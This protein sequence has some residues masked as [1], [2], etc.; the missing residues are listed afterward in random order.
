MEMF[1]LVQDLIMAVSVSR[2]CKLSTN[3]ASDVKLNQQQYNSVLHQK[4]D[5]PGFQCVCKTMI[6][7]R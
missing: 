2:I 1:R 7:T 3:L 6:C 4:I 5:D